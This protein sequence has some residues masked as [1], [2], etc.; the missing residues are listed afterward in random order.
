ML[1]C[2]GWGECWHDDVD[3]GDD[4]DNGDDGGRSQ[5]SR[6]ATTPMVGIRLVWE[7]AG[8]GGQEIFKHSVML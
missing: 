6:G 5:G 2:W 7:Q 4:A 3:D 8:E 1:S